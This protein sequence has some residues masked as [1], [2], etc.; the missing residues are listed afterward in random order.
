MPVLRVKKK[1]RNNVCFSVHTI[2]ISEE[3]KNRCGATVADVSVPDQVVEAMRE[4]S[5]Y[6]GISVKACGYDND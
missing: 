6:D 4:S 3:H 2:R 1:I 5:G